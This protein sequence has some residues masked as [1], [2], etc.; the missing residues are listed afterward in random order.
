ME[1]RLKGKVAL[2]TGGGRGIGEGIA[3]RLAAEGALVWI[4]DIDEPAAKSVATSL[5]GATHSRVDITSDESVA[6]LAAAIA[7]RHGHLDILVNNAAILDIIPLEELTPAHHAKVIEVN[8]NG[9]VRVS[10]AMVPLLRKAKDGARI[11]N[12][13]S[14]NGLRGSRDN[15][16]YSVAKGG[17]VNLTRCLAT[18]LGADNITVNAIAPGF[19]DTR[20]SLLPDGS[21]E[22]KTEWFQDIYIKYGR[23]PL[24]RG[25]TP[26]DI[27]GPAFFLCS[28]DS[29]YVTGQI[30]TVDGGMLATF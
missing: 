14:V 30:L 6:S 28:D 27:A 24:R 7:A 1:Q 16:P 20:M 9:A 4:A 3:R 5:E 8:L 17:I 26:A 11:V 23:I 22:H 19:I 12:L 21:H 2:V 10:L 18:D 25:G 13:A 15:I 29:R